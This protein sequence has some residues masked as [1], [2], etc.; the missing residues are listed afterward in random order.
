MYDGNNNLLSKMQVFENPV[1]TSF[2]KSTITNMYDGNNNLLSSIAIIERPAG[3]PASK[4]TITNTYDTNNNLLTQ[5]EVFESP[6]GT[7]IRKETITNTYNANNSLL[8]KIE[9]F[10][11]PVGTLTFKETQTNTYDVNNNLLSSIEVD[12]SPVGTPIRKETITNT[13]DAN[14]NLLTRTNVYERPVGTVNSSES[15][16]L[17]PCS[18]LMGAI[19]TKDINLNAVD[20][21]SCEDPKNRTINGIFLFH[22]VLTV[23]SVPGRSIWLSANDGEFRDANNNPIPAGFLPTSDPGGNAGGT[24]TGT[25]IPE[26]STPGTYQLEFYHR[27]NIAS[28]ISYTD[29]NTTQPFVTSSCATCTVIPTMSEWGLLIFGLLVMNLGLFFMKR[30]NIVLEN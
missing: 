9:V 8:T 2:F 18:D 6:V 10:E 7:P 4:E 24:G 20:P 16:T 26:T 28:T 15:V 27:E 3:T 14:S 11:R 5:I 19:D 1:G 23:T 21:C 12:E 29:G 30:Q 13:Y 22:D 17:T 25:L